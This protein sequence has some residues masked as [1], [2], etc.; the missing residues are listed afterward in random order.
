MIISYELTSVCNICLIIAEI[1]EN[2]NCNCNILC[3]QIFE[4]NNKLNELPTCEMA[5]KQSARIIYLSL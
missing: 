5:L 2:C 1:T 3:Y 4:G